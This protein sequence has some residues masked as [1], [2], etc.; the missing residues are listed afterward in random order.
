ML[1]AGASTARNTGLAASRA[2]WVLLLDDDVVPQP[3]LLFCY[4][5]QLEAWGSDPRIFGFAGVT[6][7]V[8]EPTS[9]WALAVRLSGMTVNFRWGWTVCM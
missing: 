2:E 4:A 5:Q 8:G 9:L 3:D 7:L 6:H 1:P